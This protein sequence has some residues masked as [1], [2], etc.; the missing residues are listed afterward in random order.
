MNSEK[1]SSHSNGNAWSNCESCPG[2]AA[3]RPPQF[4]STL[5]STAHSFSAVQIRWARVFAAAVGLVCVEKAFG[6]SATS[7]A[8]FLATPLPMFGPYFLTLMARRTEGGKLAHATAVKER[9]YFK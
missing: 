7:T 2:T 3:S 9:R 5:A 1:P 6:L 4:V 8:A